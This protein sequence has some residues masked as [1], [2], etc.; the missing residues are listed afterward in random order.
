MI[1]ALSKPPFELGSRRTGCRDGDGHWTEQPYV[2][3]R[4]VTFDEWVAFI[5][6]QLSASELA[7]CV[8]GCRAD[9]FFEVSTD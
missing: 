1:L 6:P 8:R 7:Y 4:E 5:R 3:I 9:R 2:L